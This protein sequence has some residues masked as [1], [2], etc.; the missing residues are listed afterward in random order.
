VAVLGPVVE[1]TTDL[2]A[3]A[4][5]YVFQRGAIRAKSV[6]D[7]LSWCAVSL[8][9][10]LQ[11]GKCSLLIPGLG[12]VALE[13]LTFMIDGTP[14]VMLVPVDLHENLIE[15][16]LPL[17]M[18]THVGG[19]LRSDLTGED[20]AEPIDPEPHAFMADIDPTLVKKVFNISKREWE[21]DIH[22]HRELDDFR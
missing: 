8:H 6:R 17:S 7:D 16:P 12:N 21:P 10:F 19:A 1:V 18:L 11:K 22:H 2:L 3:V 9:C 15:M 13:H 20:R 4:I 14:E 5:P